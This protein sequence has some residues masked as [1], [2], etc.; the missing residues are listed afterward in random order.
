MDVFEISARG[1]VGGLKMVEAEPADFANMQRMVMREVRQR[2]YRPRY[3]DAQAVASPDQFL[4]HTFYY[5]QSDLDK[6]R[7]AATVEED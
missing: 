3:Q 5:R 1:R 7:A 4:E 6:I 2:L